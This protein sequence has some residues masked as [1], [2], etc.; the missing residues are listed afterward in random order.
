MAFQEKESKDIF[1]KKKSVLI[2]VLFS[3]IVIMDAEK[4]LN[5]KFL[6]W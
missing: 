3:I 6:K 1:V 5:K 2:V 4:R